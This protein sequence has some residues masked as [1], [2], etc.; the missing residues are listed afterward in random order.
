MHSSKMCID[1]GFR[2][3]SEG[4]ETESQLKIVKEAGIQ[5][6]QGWYFSKA[7]PTEEAKQFALSFNQ[8]HSSGITQS[9]A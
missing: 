5:F 6:V 3:V 7:L 2:L 8:N 4:I 9:N 1:L